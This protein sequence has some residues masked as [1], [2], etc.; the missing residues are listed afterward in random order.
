MI[1]RLM[2]Q[3]YT[4]KMRRSAKPGVN[5]ESAFSVPVPVTKF[6]VDALSQPLSLQRLG[7]LSQ[8]L[9]PFLCFAIQGT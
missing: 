1:D 9:F 4:S 3:F 8:P 6:S 5:R 2:D 7:T